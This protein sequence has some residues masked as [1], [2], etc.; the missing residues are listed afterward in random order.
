MLSRFAAVNAIANVKALNLRTFETTMKERLHG[1]PDLPRKIS[2][3][4]NEIAFLNARLRLSEE[5]FRKSRCFGAFFSK[6]LQ[7]LRA[8]M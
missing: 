1:S 6:S 5:I 7:A 8:D 3:E 4:E 2:N